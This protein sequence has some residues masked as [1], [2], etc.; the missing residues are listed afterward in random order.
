[1]PEQ[2]R[3]PGQSSYTQPPRDTSA[4]IKTD[5]NG[6]RTPNQRLNLLEV[7]I[8][9]A[10]KDF[11]GQDITSNELSQLDPQFVKTA[12]DALSGDYDVPPI[13][14][15]NDLGNPD[16]VL[17]DDVFWVEPRSYLETDETPGR[18]DLAREQER[19]LMEE[20]MKRQ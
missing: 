18:V 9:Q 15:W 14:Y 6:G 12:R 11:P 7:L 13:G 5:P 17:D 20:L 2:P 8:G 10:M 3:Y 4:L 1:M 16:S 19:L